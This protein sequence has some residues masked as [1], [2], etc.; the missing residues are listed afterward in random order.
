M[1]KPILIILG[2][3]VAANVLAWSIAFNGSQAL[4]VVFFDV[5]QGD[6]IFIEDPYG[7]QILIDGGPDMAVVNK[8]AQEMPLGD[9]TIDL[10][11]LTH[12]DHDHINGLIEVLKQYQVDN[13]LWTGLTRETAE[14]KKWHELVEEEGA[15]VIIAKAGQ[16]LLFA[17]DISLEILYP[18]E[19]L[20]GQDPK[21]INNTSI[22][23]RLVFEGSSFLFTGDIYQSVEKEIA[24]RT[25]ILKISHHGSKTSSAEEFIQEVAPK[26]A[27]ISVG[28][29][30]P[31][32]HPHQTVLAVL[33]KFAISV[34]RTDQDGDIKIISNG[35]DYKIQ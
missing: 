18:K 8:L 3:L 34:L 35:A 20:A 15:Q 22:V 28:Q 6:A 33:E 2:A 30:N 14:F 26:I 23:A 11:I 16:R 27:V 21:N 29:D 13:I 7:H 17:P 25:D 19:D 32:G 10:M 31:Y 5:G 1:K 12:P 9:K 24:V 4:E